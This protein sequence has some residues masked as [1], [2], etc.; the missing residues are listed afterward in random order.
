MEM[1]EGSVVFYTEDGQ[2][3][4]GRVTDI[5]YAN[6]GFSF[7]IDSYGDCSGQHRIQSSQIGKTVFFSEEDARDAVK[8]D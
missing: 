2:I 7:S 3:Y 5:E 6:I 4:S 8:E 1:E